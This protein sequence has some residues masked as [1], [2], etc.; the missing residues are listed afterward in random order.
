MNFANFRMLVLVRLLAKKYASC[1]LV[2]FKGIILLNLH[3]I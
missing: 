2:N 1:E 3:K